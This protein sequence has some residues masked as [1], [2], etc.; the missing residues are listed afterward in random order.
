M[1]YPTKVRG[2]LESDIADMAAHPERLA[3]RP[4]KDFTRRRKLDLA[5]TVELLVTMGTGSISH[6]L[7]DH[8]SYEPA[9]VPTKSAFC[10]QRA[11]LLPDALREL[12]R[13]FASRFG[14]AEYRAGCALVAADGSSFCFGPDRSD[15]QTY[16]PNREGTRGHN[17]VH[18]VAL[19]DMVGDSYLDA[20]VQRGRGKDEF[21][22]MCELVDA[23]PAW[24]SGLM[25]AV[26]VADRGFASYNVFAHVIEAGQLFAIRAK[27][28]NVRRMLEPGGGAELPDEMDVDVSL[29][30]SRTTAKS[31]VAQP[32]RMGDYRRVDGAGFDFLDG[33]RAEY[34]MGLRIVRFPIAGGF[35]NIVTNLPRGEFGPDE[36][37]AI[38]GMRWG[39]ETSFR[40]LKLNIGASDLHSRRAALVAQEI[41]ARMVLYD[42]CAAIARYAS[43][44]PQVAGKRGKKHAHRV[45]FADAARSCC[46]FLRGRARG[47][48]VVE[49]V[50]GS[51]S[52][53]R[54][55]RR[56]DRRHRLRSPSGQTY[57]PA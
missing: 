19:Y 32:E 43:T 14:L 39:V 25:A 35:E 18:A 55:G 46:A 40:K 22:A 53:V 24:A 57:R 44:L 42:F 30:L 23:W 36:I 31:K 21:S 3:K 37:R 56:F 7:M 45:N 34:E 48:D 28:L 4:G 54:P 27:D 12:L 33:V 13:A 51:T 38:Y 6:E 1:D 5:S 26:F 16:H 8:F 20:V 29:I 11:K 2:W 9:S 17:L 41:Y 15:P 10:Q 49:L 47:P 52:P 50:A